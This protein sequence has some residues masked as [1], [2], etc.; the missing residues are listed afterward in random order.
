MLI[1]GESRPFI[2]GKGRP[3]FGEPR[4]LPFGFLFRFK[5]I[6]GKPIMAID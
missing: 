3:D 6:A 5:E 1:V 2:V 4:L